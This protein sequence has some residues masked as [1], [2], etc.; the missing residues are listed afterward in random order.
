MVTDV[1]SIFCSMP[2]IARTAISPNRSGWA[3]CYA[4]Y[5]TVS[6]LKLVYGDIWM[7]S[8]MTQMGATYQESFMAQ[9]PCQIDPY[10]FSLGGMMTTELHANHGAVAARNDILVKDLKRVVGDADDLLHELGKAS[11]DEFVSARTRIEASLCEA[12]AR[13][14]EARSAFAQK[15][16]SAADV[17]QEY[18]KENPWKLVGVAAAAGLL[19]AILLSSRQR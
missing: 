2:H 17:T 18:I 3:L 4:R 8:D 9:K 1:K 14:R 12:E 6:A 19:F 15:A 5:R 16:R 7:T 10:F 13:L 11:S